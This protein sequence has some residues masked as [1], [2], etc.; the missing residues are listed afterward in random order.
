MRKPGSNGSETLKNLRSAAIRLLSERGYEGMNLR[1][2]AS[3]LRLHAGS[4]YNYIESKQQLLYWL[5]KDATE[6]LLREFD[7]A[8]AGIEDPE[9]Q[10]R[11][12]V[13]FHLCH[14]LVN[15]KESSVLS[16]EMRSLTPR[17]YR[18]I[19]RLQR[20]YTDKIHDIVKRGLAAGKFS[21]D[22]SQI[23][24]F[25][26][27]QMLTSVIRW[28]SPQGRLTVDELVE[29]Y[30]NLV[31]GMLRAEN[32]AQKPHSRPN[33]RKQAANGFATSLADAGVE[34]LP[35]STLAAEN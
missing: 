27:L 33:R 6:K 30:T 18:A 13:V 12:F 8:I 14:H 17:N 11:E 26:L 19:S 7:A 3:R 1:T 31:F 24:T 25:A 2:L 9:E 4:L 34:P 15:R 5:M 23:A 28:Y 20:L 32:N 21:I 22:D 35:A 10:M 29:I 16:T